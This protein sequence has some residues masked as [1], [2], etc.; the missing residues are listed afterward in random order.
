[1]P[2]LNKIPVNK[3]D[4]ILLGIVH[5]IEVNRFWLRVYT[6]VAALATIF[7][8][9]IFH[10]PDTITSILLFIGRL[11]LAIIAILLTTLV[12]KQLLERYHQNHNRWMTRIAIIVTILASLACSTVHLFLAPRVLTNALTGKTFQLA[13]LAG[14]LAWLT[15]TLIMLAVITFA[16]T[17]FNPDFAQV[18]MFGGIV[19]LLQT[20]SDLAL[21][22]VGARQI[23]FWPDRLKA[24]MSIRDLFVH[25]MDKSKQNDII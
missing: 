20:M 3:S 1:M 19:L 25:I 15:A 4:R 12:L 5:T 14:A 2:R 13:L 21:F 6:V 22:V 23:I 17:G 10:I 8:G 24:Q 9:I 11:I 16:G 18:S 7:H